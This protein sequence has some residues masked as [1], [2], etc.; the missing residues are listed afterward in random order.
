MGCPFRMGRALLPVT[1]LVHDHGI[2]FRT[3]MQGTLAGLARPQPAAF[4]VDDIDHDT[5]TGWSVQVRGLSKAINEPAELAAL[6]PS[7]PL[8]QHIPGVPTLSIH[9]EG[10]QTTGRQIAARA[11]TGDSAED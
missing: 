5:Q 2:V 3:E 4:E 9:I 7:D 1:Y 10:R 11:T 6:W 8:T